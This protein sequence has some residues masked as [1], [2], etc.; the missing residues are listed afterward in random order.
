[1]KKLIL[2]IAGFLIIHIASAQQKTQQYAIKSGYIEYTLSGNTNGTKKIWWDNYGEKSRTETQSETTTKIFG[3]KNVDKTH[4]VQI[5]V[6]DKY[7]TA[8]LAD[9][10]GHKGTLPFY[11]ASRQLVDNMTKQE[12]EDF[13]N[14]TI[15]A[16]GGEKLGTENFMGKTCEVIKVMGSKIWLYKGLSLKSEVKMMGIESNE[17]AIKLQE[18][19]SV[20]S[21][22]FTPLSNIS[23]ENIDEQQQGMFGG[24]DNMD[25][26]DDSD[27]DYPPMIPVKYPYAKFLKKVNA[28]SYEGYKKMMAQSADGSY[29][30]AFMRGAGE[31]LV[32][33]ATSRKNVHP[34]EMGNFENFTHNGK[35]CMYGKAID[36]EE[37]DEEDHNNMM[38]IVEISQYDTYI[39]I[40]S[41]VPQT[42]QELLEIFDQLE[43]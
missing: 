6:K 12:Q 22:K 11:Q 34:N 41:P 25:D 2:I 37:E 42:K 8:N 13:A 29:G 39:T 38:L 5:L 30:A 26:S 32:V 20:P 1:M 9:Q 33:G 17:T 23:Y 21:S 10:S 40:G 27:D 31:I 4:T 28:F 18:N 35:K 3:I 19:Q 36:E 43:F 14:Q 16:L 15:A 24:M 7:W